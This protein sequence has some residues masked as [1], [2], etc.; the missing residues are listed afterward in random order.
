MSALQRQTYA[1]STQPL[2]VPIGGGTIQG[3]LV[4]EGSVES[5]ADG[6][7][8]VDANGVVKAALG[9]SGANGYVASQSGQRLYFGGYSG[10]PGQSYIQPAA[11]TNQD[12]LVVG[13]SVSTQQLRVAVGANTS[14]GSGT[15]VNGAATITTTAC[16]GVNS[17]IF[18][19][20]T[21][22]NASTALGELRIRQRNVGSFLVE[23]STMTT[24]PAL[25]AETGDQSDFDWI[26][27]NPA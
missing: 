5:V 21:N 4:V 19:V 3:D 11:S 14:M 17:R 18:L 12:I 16:I 27:I 22:V 25:G 2:F 10:L 24:P 6:F 1:N 8:V 9:I 26:I 15:L 7:Q 13:G 20:R 23:S